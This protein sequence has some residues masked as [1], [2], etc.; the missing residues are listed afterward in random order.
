MREYSGLGLGSYT[1]KASQSYGFL[2]VFL[3]RANFGSDL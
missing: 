3:S 1:A 2:L